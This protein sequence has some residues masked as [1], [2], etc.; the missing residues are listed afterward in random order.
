MLKIDYLTFIIEVENKNCW[1][2]IPNP[3]LF[4]PFS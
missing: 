4:I 3:D 1:L 2:E